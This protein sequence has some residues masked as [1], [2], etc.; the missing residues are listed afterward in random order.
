MSRI[1]VIF[2]TTEGHTAKVAERLGGQLRLQGHATD[3]VEAGDGTTINPDEYDAVIVAASVHAGAYQR[4]V[5]RWVSAH[6]AALNRKPT[7][8]ASVCLGVLQH[9]PGVDRDLRAIV[10]AFFRSTGWRPLAT[11]IVAGALQYTRYNFVKRWV[12][13][14]IARKAGGDTDTTR[15]YEYTDWADLQSFADRFSHQ[16]HTVPV[17]KTRSQT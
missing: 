6:A 11:A 16:L 15:D 13:K 1:L 9:D 8:F 12:M 17:V 7:A 4:E 2:G 14:R 10:E 3:V 5:V